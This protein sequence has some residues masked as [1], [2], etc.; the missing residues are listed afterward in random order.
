MEF[1]IQVKGLEMAGYDPRSMFGQGLAYA[2]ANR[3]ACHLS[4]YMV[5]FE[6][7]F[8]MLDPKTTLAKPTF[9]K[10]MEDVYCVVNAL[11]I[12]QFTTAAFMLESPIVR[13][14]PHTLVSLFMQ[15]LPKIATLVLD[16]SLFSGFWS[17]ITGLKMSPSQIKKCGAR[18]H[19]LE[20]YMNTR[21]GISKK[22][23]RLPQRLLTQ[24]RRDDPEDL[25]VPLEQ[26]ITRY[27]K[28]R[29]YDNNGI[30]THK[31]LKKLDIIS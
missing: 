24:A 15:F 25:T 29:G 11:H 9:T 2:V 30:P 5:A 31:L 23:D 26:M 10:T 6:L 16:M 21:E 12:C 19:T 17:S 18:I 7:L 13:L 4:A 20:R 22:D 27:Y 14:L 3:G 28:T 8:G 1:A